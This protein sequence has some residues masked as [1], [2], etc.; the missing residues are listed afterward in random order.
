MINSMTEK[1]ISY[2]F[3]NGRMRPGYDNKV[4]K[5]YGKPLDKESKVII[6]TVI[7]NDIS[8]IQWY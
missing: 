8:E 4:N 7:D 6:T 3:M 2:H 1:A 5:V